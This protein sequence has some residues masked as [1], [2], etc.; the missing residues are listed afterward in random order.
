MRVLVTGATGFVGRAACAALAAAGAEVVATARDGRGDVPLDLETG[1]V[2]GALARLRP[3]AVVNCAGLAAGTGPARLMAAN[4]WAAARLLA[5]AEAAGVARLVLI[6]SAAAYAPMREGQAAIAEDH[7]LAPISA[8]GQSKAALHR[9]GAAWAARG[10]MA[11]LTAVPFNLFGPGQPGRQ[12]PQA[13]VAQLRARPAAITV[14][15]LAAVRDWV[16]VRDAARALALLATGAA[17]PG[18]YNIATGR[19]LATG[20]LLDRLCALTGQAPARIADPAMQARPTLS[21]S[22]GDPARLAGCGWRP[23]L[24][25]DQSLRD[26]LAAA[27]A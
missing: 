16:D 23:H 4:H 25:P 12:A 11:V 2:A 3:Q 20:D 27:Q 22:I 14:G 10:R 9:L 5:A 17:P 7:P 13:F 1:D 6:G 18:P 24:S 8:Y 15:D 21:A 19:G 26:M